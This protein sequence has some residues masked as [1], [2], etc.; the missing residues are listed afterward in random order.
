MYSLHTNNP[1]AF[2]PHP[3]PLFFQAE[4]LDEK[5]VMSAEDEVLLEDTQ[6]FSFMI[7]QIK[8]NAQKVLDQ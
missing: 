7:A 2:C 5:P 6:E 8:F 4:W 3:A 1:T